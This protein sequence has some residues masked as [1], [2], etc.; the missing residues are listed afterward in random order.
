MRN[1]QI[2]MAFAAAT[3]AA[4]VAALPAEAQPADLDIETLTV[5][6]PCAPGEI[7]RSG[8]AA[9]GTSVRCVAGLTTAGPAWEADG[10][11][12]QQIGRLQGQG[13]NVVVSRTGTAGAD[14]TVASAAAPDDAAAAPNTVNVTLICPE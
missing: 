9:N 2:S 5:G 7:N 1:L 12:V 14:C 8:V 10:Q 13:L 11:G 3:T 6:A 4:L